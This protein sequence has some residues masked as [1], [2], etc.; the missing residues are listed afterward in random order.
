MISDKI[1]LLGILIIGFAL[2][3][4]YL[5]KGLGF[6]DENLYYEAGL[7]ILHN[8]M[9]IFTLTVIHTHPPLHWIYSLTSI[10][11]IIYMRYTS[12]IIGTFCILVLYYFMKKHIGK[13][14]AL[15]CSG[16]FA[17]T[18]YYVM[19]SRIAYPS[20]LIILFFIIL[21]FQFIMY[22]KNP[23][24]KNSLIYGIV[25]T[26]IILLKEGAILFI[27]ATILYLLWDNKN[28]LKTKN[29][30]IG[31][32]FPFTI[33]IPIL[34]YAVYFILPQHI[35]GLSIFELPRFYQLYL[36]RGL[37]PEYLLSGIW[38]IFGIFEKF[39]SLP[40]LFIFLFGVFFSLC[41]RDNLDKLFLSITFVYLLFFAMMYGSSTV[42]EF[43][44]RHIKWIFI[45]ILI[46]SAK[47]ITEFFKT[48][49][50]I[51]KY[52]FSVLIILFVISTIILDLSIINTM[53]QF[54]IKNYNALPLV[55]I[56]LNAD[57][58]ADFFNA[59]IRR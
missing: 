56:D 29:F 53:N 52:K 48:H 8:P 20:I 2:R 25:L 44:D 38:Y 19:L 42:E 28:L 4:I 22:I 10:N 17:I 5:D 23:T 47:M 24:L 51:E 40:M 26:I 32:L 55:Q 30:W 34:L 11:G 31:T 9:Y 37:H 35:T 1:K 59:S 33:L 46:M 36:N 50:I 3:V 58:I 7:K 39:S 49:V 16:L 43:V 12:A 27:P 41:R 45:P 54:M 57:K 14:E 13:Q 15:I 18:G 21:I 6:S